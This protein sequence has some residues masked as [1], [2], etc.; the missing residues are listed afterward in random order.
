MV[1]APAVQR[2]ITFARQ[3]RLRVVV[4]LALQYPTVDAVLA[5]AGQ[6]LEGKVLIDTTNRVDPS[7]PPTS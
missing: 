4:V 2:L 7:D 6:A 5:E 3:G 1:P